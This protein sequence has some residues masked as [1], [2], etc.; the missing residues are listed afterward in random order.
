MLEFEKPI[1]R[2]E[3]E[4][5]EIEA[6]QAETRRDLSVELRE[7]RTTLTSLTKRTYA[8]LTPWET[9]LVARHPRRPVLR[10]YIDGWLVVCQM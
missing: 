3:R 2:I 1:A 4:I 6:A 9:V 10:H 7:L 5:A 8:K